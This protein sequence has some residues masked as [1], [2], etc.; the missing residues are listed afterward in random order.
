MQPAGCPPRSSSQAPFTTL[1]QTMLTTT[2]P[3]QKPMVA[4]PRQVQ[5]DRRHRGPAGVAR[6]IG[7]YRDSAQDSR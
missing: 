2:T 3:E 6:P 1:E 5:R 7:H 4:G